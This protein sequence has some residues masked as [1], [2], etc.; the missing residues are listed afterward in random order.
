MAGR[1][2]GRPPLD[3]GR[4]SRVN[5][6]HRGWPKARTKPVYYRA[7]YAMDLLGSVFDVDF[8]QVVDVGSVGH[9][10]DRV[11]FSLTSCSSYTSRDRLS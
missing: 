7:K 1:P 9:P 3:L 10:T 4:A 2:L 5:A 11:Q 6:L 8:A